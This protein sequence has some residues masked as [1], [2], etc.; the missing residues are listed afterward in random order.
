LLLLD[1]LA[2]DQP[3]G[4]HLRRVHRPRDVR[5]RRFQNGADARVERIVL[6]LDFQWPSRAAAAR[7]KNMTD[8]RINAKVTI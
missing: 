7:N 4:D 2:P 6:L 5:P 1:D 3:V 8:P